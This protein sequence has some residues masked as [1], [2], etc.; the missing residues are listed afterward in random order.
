[1]D[2]RQLNV[3]VAV[4]DHGGFSA[5][6][7]ALHTVQSNVSSHIARL[8]KELGVTLVDRQ[9]GRLTDE[10]AVVVARARRVN[11]ELEAI[12][13]DLA[14]L[15][16]E[17]AGPVRV[18]IIGTTAR[19]LVPRILE[20]VERHPGIRLVVV[21]A[22]S[23]SLEPRLAAGELDLAV[24]NLPLPV[25]DLV[26]EPLFDEDLVLVVPAGHPLATAGRVPLAELAGLELLLPPPTTAFRGELD[27]AA[28]N[29]GIRL[30]PLAELDG[31]R[32]IASLAMEGRGPAIVPAT[33]VSVASLKGSW[34]SV[35]VDG[36]PR[37]RV[38][39][40]QRRRGML[41]APARALLEILRE[42]AASPDNPPGLHPPG[43]PPRPWGV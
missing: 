25:R 29:V 2:L 38:G 10:G 40:A 35:A 23:T 16:D 42:I 26:E 32:L 9:A 15:R 11:G 30:T 41:A 39:V 34:A 3:V 37:R 21:D 31:L 36:L 33:A 28:A 14:A 13:A 12:V 20:L 19:W 5:A 24:I 1:M 27:A 4:A 22:T 6:A 8:E 43:P 17:I 7:D 18:G